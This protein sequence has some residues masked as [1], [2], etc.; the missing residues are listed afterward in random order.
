MVREGR[1]AYKN[2]AGKVRARGKWMGFCRRMGGEGGGGVGAGEGGQME[3]M[4]GGGEGDGEAEGEA[5]GEE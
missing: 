2:E 4:E 3:G 1:S 5:E